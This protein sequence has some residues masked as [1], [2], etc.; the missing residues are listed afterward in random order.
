MLVRVEE[1]PDAKPMRKRPGSSE[2]IFD[3]IGVMWAVMCSFLVESYIHQNIVL[4]CH[5]GLGRPE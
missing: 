4:V 2:M 5:G 1:K 3:I